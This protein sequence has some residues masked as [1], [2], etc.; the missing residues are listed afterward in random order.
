[1]SSKATKDGSTSGVESMRFGHA[2]LIRVSIRDS[3][4]ALAP[5]RALGHCLVLDP[6]FALAPVRV[7]DH[8]LALYSSPC[9][10]RVGALIH[11]R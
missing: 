4:L 9:L 1:M 3:I 11:R 5:V 2:V 8:F 6:N 7:L 10:A